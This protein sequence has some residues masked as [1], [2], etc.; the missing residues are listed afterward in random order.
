MKNNIAKFGGDPTRITVLGESAGAGSILAHTV[1][2]GG[3]LFNRAITQSP[4]QVEITPSKQ[5]EIYQ[6]VMSTAGVSTLKALKSLSTAEL[7]KTNALVVGNSAPW[8]FTVFGVYYRG[9]AS[10]LKGLF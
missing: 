4:V 7:Q 3:A 6:K 5:E 10:A 9:F 1:S 2:K 8:A